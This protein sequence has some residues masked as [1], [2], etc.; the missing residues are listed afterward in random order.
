[1]NNNGGAQMVT[2][3]RIGEVRTRLEKIWLREDGIV[4]IVA[5]SLG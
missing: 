1:M 2:D 3:N 4:Q 5:V